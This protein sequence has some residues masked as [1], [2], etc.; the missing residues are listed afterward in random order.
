MVNSVVGGEKNDLVSP[1][2]VYPFAV[3]DGQNLRRKSSSFAYNNKGDYTAFEFPKIVRVQTCVPTG[4]TVT[5]KQYNAEADALG[6]K[7]NGVVWD[8]KTS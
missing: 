3:W 2:G 8:V 5:V 4:T 7:A 6:K 1:C